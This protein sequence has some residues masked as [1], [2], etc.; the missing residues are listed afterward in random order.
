LSSGYAQTKWVAER[1]VAQAGE[2]GLPV[3]IHRAGRIIGDSRTGEW[4]PGDAT[5][6]LLRVSAHLGEVPDL[7]PIDLTPLDYV[8]DAIVTLADRPSCAGRV[9]HLSH[10]SPTSPRVLAD[11]LARAGRPVSVVPVEQWFADLEQ[12]GD[13]K[14]FASPVTLFGQWVRG[15]RNGQREPLF[16]ST[17]T[18]GELGGNCPDV[19]ADLV[20]RYVGYFESVGYLPSAPNA[21]EQRNLQARG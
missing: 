21:R 5:G 18:T 9:F 15:Y 7:D 10:P 13:R 6:E 20:A 1:L 19:D 4:R 12:C 8:A 17:C 3:R 14:E 11:G 16:D 2:R